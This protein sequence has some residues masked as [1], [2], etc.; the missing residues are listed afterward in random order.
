MPRLLA[1][2]TLGWAMAI[3]RGAEPGASGSFDRVIVPPARTSIYLGTVTMTMPDFERKAGVFESSYQAK[4]FPFFFSN[5]QGR[6]FIEIS[7]DLLDR[8]ARGQSVDFKGRGVRDDGAERRL[9]G[10][11]TP[12]DATGGR[13]KVRVFVSKRIELIFNTTYRFASNPGHR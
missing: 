1:L 7:D 10:S 3:A 6:V 8:L 12:V 4:V 2:F 11:A 5:E 13:L 9:E